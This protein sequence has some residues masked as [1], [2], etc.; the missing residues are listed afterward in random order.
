MNFIHLTRCWADMAAYV[1]GDWRRCRA[2]HGADHHRIL[3]CDARNRLRA[4]AHIPC[5][6][7]T[8]Y[9]FT[10]P[11][12]HR[13]PHRTNHPLNI[14]L[15]MLENVCQD[16]P[17]PCGYH[18]L[19]YPKTFLWAMHDPSLSNVC[20]LG[21]SHGES[22][23]TE[24]LHAY[25]SAVWTGVKFKPTHLETW[26]ANHA[27]TVSYRNDTTEINAF[28]LVGAQFNAECTGTSCANVRSC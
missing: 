28:S 15:N 9:F 3:R 7:P 10:Q 19:L 2:D 26:H 27:G 23:H 25:T 8:A 20:G 11:T 21:T 16:W 18:S 12:Y 6:L 1:A 13:C 4:G 22:Q 17:S 14:V 5:Q 24:T